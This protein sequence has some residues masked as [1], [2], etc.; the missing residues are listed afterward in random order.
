[1]FIRHILV[2]YFKKNF[3]KNKEIINFKNFLIF[4]KIFLKIDN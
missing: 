4:Y 3:F 1:M 2:N